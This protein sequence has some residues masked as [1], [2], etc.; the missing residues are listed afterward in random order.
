[1]EKNIRRNPKSNRKNP[2][3]NKNKTTSDALLSLFYSSQTS[4]YF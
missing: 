4:E 2:T 3:Q 1:V